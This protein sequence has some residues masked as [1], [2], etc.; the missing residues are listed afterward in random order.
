MVTTVL[1]KGFK[2]I[3]SLYIHVAVQS[4][5]CDNF[6]VLSVEALQTD[7][8]AYITVSQSGYQ[9]PK[10]NT[11]KQLTHKLNKIRQAII[12]FKCGSTNIRYFKNA[13]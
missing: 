11:R 9:R 6:K 3:S 7:M 1:V 8:N 4:I 2:F 12:K 13:Q 10:L 5:F